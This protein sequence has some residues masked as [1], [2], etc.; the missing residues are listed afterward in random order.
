MIYLDHAATTPLDPRVLEEMMPYLTAKFGNPGSLHSCGRAAKNAVDKARERVA[1]FFSC[2]PEQI[3]F[4]SGGS[5]GNSTVF[6]GLETELRRRGRTSVAVTATEHDSVRKAARKLCLRPD[7]KLHTVHP[8]ENGWYGE[9]EF[10]HIAEQ[11]CT[12][13]VSAMFVNNETG[14][15]NDVT[16][17]GSLCRENGVLFHVDAVQAAGVLPLDVDGV[18]ADFMT[19]SSHKINGPKGVGA[20][21][22][23]CPELLAPLIIGGA[24][25]E[26][27]FRGGTEN[28]A[29]IVGLGAACE[30]AAQEYSKHLRYLQ[31]QHSQLIFM[32]LSKAKE[33][34][35]EAKINGNV[36]NMSP[37]TV[38]ICFPG[39][40]AETLLLFLDASGICIS[41][42]SACRAHENN[43]SHVLTAMGISDDD[44]RSSVRISISHLNTPEE[45][46]EASSAIVN[47]AAMLKGVS[48]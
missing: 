44:A 18:R 36:C 35:V 37:K 30:F 6:F 19:V 27:G 32:L 1:S 3:I 8:G 29:G 13:L 20:L 48:P 31:A 14:L 24:D 41:A 16:A 26:F 47:C 38:N 21:F 45:L 42:G 43:P 2:K 12:G 15:V 46:N 40:D 34:G 33:A 22:A 17:I 11:P 7:F 23:R 4:T 10:L 25:Q 5:E 28:V 39:V 9:R